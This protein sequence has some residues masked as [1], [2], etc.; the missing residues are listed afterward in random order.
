[1]RPKVDG[2]FTK[3]RP[4]R[5]G[6][7]ALA[8][9]SVLIASPAMAQQDTRRIERQLRTSEA[10]DFRV[11]VDTSLTLAERTQFDYGGFVSLTGIWLND[12]NENSRRLIQ[13]EVALY[14]RASLDG[15]HT[16]FVRSRFPYRSFSAGDSF[17]GRGDRWIEPFL[18]RYVYTFDLRR[19]LE[20]YQGM[21]T[22]FNLNLSVGR[23]FVDWGAGLALSETL[24][25]VRPVI[26]LSRQFKIDTLVGLTPEHT[27]DF[28]A[29][30][31]NSDEK[32]RRSYIGVKPTYT[33]RNGTEVYAFAL[34]MRDHYADTRG[35]PPIPSTLVVDFRTNAEYWGLGGS[36]SL[37]PDLLWQLEGIFQTGSSNSDPFRDPLGQQ[38][39]QDIYAGAARGQLTWLVRD[40]ARSRVQGEVL[41][42]TG[43]GDRNVTT[44][45]IG[46]NRRFTNDEAFNSLGL[47]NTGLA[48]APALSN[49]ISTRLGAS[50][51]P[52]AGNDVFDQL[53]L[54]A[55]LLLFN[56]YTSRGA[57]DQP[58]RDASFLGTELD[59]YAN[60]RIT[61][62]LAV[63]ARYGV[64]FP[65]AGL[66]NRD[67]RHFLLLGVTLSF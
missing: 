35:R 23:Q 55:D 47:A 59:L 58:S 14:A 24:Y 65:G 38:S 26:E 29:S 22:D 33:F 63:Q 7:I 8:A 17:D 3:V 20:A 46:G 13:P 62:D 51:F 61:G 28:D 9:G 18:D 41:M 60:W 2:W 1:M 11:R 32:T 34:I 30:R 64:F 48:F 36:G 56:K 57:I 27:A 21:S 5:A 66:Q 42:F 45:T 16:V 12:S 25:A 31:F 6:A 44:D 37:G 40:A 15:V 43:D 52:L 10:G 67:T 54:G 19:A 4:L 49:L 39:K 53:Q 50:T